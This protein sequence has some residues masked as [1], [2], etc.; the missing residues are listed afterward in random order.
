MQ[1]NFGLAKW[2]DND[3]EGEED[4]IMLTANS[5]LFE[6]YDDNSKK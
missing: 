3:I 5:D 4:M 2:N 6:G 1:K